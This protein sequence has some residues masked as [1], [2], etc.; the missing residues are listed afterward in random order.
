M[1]CHPGNL[2]VNYRQR[3]LLTRIIIESTHVSTPAGNVVLPELFVDFSSANMPARNRVAL[4]SG[5][6]DYLHIECCVLKCPLTSSMTSTPVR[7]RLL[8]SREVSNHASCFRQQ[9][10]LSM[11]WESQSSDI[12]QRFFVTKMS[13]PETC[14]TE[15]TE[16]AEQLHTNHIRS[17]Q[18]WASSI[19]W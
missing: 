13:F 17:Q 9:R 8:K 12:G 15:C 19:P 3:W 2:L 5:C 7:Y 10:V 11:R 16:V 6:H 18:K 1:E 14:C 4:S